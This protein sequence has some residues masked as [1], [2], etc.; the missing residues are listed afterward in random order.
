MGSWFRILACIAVLGSCCSAALEEDLKSLVQRAFELHQKGQFAEALPLLRRAY[1]LEP[2][3]YFVNLLL[4]ID[5][6]RTGQPKA[7]VPFLKKAS[8]LRPREEFPLDYLGEAYARQD[9]YGEA[10]EARALFVIVIIVLVFVER[11]A[12]VG[13][14]INAQ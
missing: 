13:A 1:A 12:A 8:R 3:D 5:S 2:G 14:A 9:I 6:L 11:K 7:A 4:G 10:A